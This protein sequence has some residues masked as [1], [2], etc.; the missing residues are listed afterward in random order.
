MARLFLCSLVFV[1]FRI[2]ENSI[3]NRYRPTFNG[4]VL[5]IKESISQVSA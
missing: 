4:Y 2:I 3:V 5:R 1:F